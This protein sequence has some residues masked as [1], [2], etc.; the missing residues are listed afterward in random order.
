MDD[1][2]LKGTGATYI[3]TGVN[4]GRVTNLSGTFAGMSNLSDA[5]GGT[6]IADGA[7]YTL[8]GPNSGKVTG[9]TGTFAGMVNLRDADDEKGKDKGG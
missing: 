9:L 4:T 1:D 3:L 2:T 6:L 5:T 7:V 8:T